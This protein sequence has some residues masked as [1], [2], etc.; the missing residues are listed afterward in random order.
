MARILV[1]DDNELLCRLTCE[2]LR[3]EGF[4]AVPAV[5]TRQALEAF[6]KEPSYSRICRNYGIS[7]LI[8]RENVSC[9]DASHLK[10]C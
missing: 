10:L 7:S 3:T 8:V 1:V 4:R 9:R 2:I 6:E 5:S